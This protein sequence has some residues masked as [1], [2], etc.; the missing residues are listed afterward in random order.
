[1]S[2]P[3]DFATLTLR[4]AQD[5]RLRGSSIFSVR[6]EPFDKAQDRL[7]GAESKDTTSRNNGF[8]DFSPSPRCPC[9]R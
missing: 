5:E 3:F 4:Y 8:P 9:L 7:H 2:T 1:M 6:P